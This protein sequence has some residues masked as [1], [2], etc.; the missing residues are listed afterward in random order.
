[1]RESILVDEENKTI[2]IKIEYKKR[3]LATE[4]KEVYSGNIGDLIPTEYVGR[5]RLIN[6]PSNP[7]SNLNDRGHCSC[8][9]WIYKI[10][11][12]TTTKRATNNKSA[13]STS[14]SRPRR[15]KA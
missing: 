14:R 12:P 3:K 1:M 13:R 11:E 6:S 8:G 7:I 9:E 15:K 5:V 2:T 10:L 4:P